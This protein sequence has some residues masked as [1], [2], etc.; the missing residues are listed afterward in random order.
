M[1]LL[2]ID[3]DFNLSKVLVYQLQKNGYDV[4]TAKNGE[5]GLSLFL[6]NDFDIV[7]TDIQMPD[8]TGIEV[9]RR[10]RHL[11]NEVIVIIITA[12][13]S[14]ENAIEACRLGANDYLTKPFG[15]EQLLFVIEK[16]IQ[17]KQLQDENTLLKQEVAGRYKIDNMIAVSAKMQEVIKVTTQVAQRNTT[18][19]ITGESGTGKELIA[20]AIH[21]NSK[22]NTKPLVTVNCPSIPENLIESELFGHV[23]GAFTG[24]I[25]DRKGKFELADGG[26]IFLDEI[27][28]LRSDLQ[29]KLL[30]VLQ[31]QEFQA[32][33][34]SQTIKVDVRI[35]AA[36]NKDLERLVKEEKF[37]EDLYYRLNVV[38]IKIDPLRERREDIPY[39]LDFFINKY[40]QGR[41][42]KLNKETVQILK[43]YDWPGN[44]RERVITL[45]TN[46]ELSPADLPE[47]ILGRI[48]D[49]SDKTFRIPEEGIGLE[50]LERK[51]IL[52]T[53]EKTEGNKSKSARL[54]K[55][56]RHVLLYKL[57]KL[58]LK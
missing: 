16:A 37:R 30:R 13:G 7:V 41:K 11:N 57:K 45:T 38:P 1:K 29:A 44:V 21:Y 20:R 5:E 56:H 9:L 53:L 48:Q 39:L 6:K 54:L 15:Q 17:F 51:V 14:V 12:H 25:S 43:N 23:K 58:G 24:A 52:N 22:R 50:D 42:F 18:V 31:E 35:I 10:I 26:S 55:I 28:D 4:S 46:E 49:N 19:L 47:H 27:G 33:G 3:D 34:G 2:L 36:T 8:I 40:R 32:V